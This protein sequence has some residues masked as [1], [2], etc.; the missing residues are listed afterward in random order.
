M[1]QIGGMNVIYYKRQD[2]L[3]VGF[4]NRDLFDN[5]KYMELFAGVIVSQMINDLDG[6]D[7]L[8]GFPLKK[9]N[10]NPDQINSISL[11][12]LLKDKSL[13]ADDDIDICIG[14]SS[15]TYLSK[16][17]ITRVPAFGNRSAITALKEILSKKLLVSTDTSICLIINIENNIVFD[18]NELKSVLKDKKVPYGAIFVVGKIKENEWRFKCYRIFPDFAESDEIDIHL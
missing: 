8:V 13:I 18:I 1:D 6:I 11:I 5:K 2:I 4:Q 12:G 14:D 17:Q 15:R 10:R 16:C 7:T 3:I 9:T